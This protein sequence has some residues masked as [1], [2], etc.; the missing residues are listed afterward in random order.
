MADKPLT[1]IG[2]RPTDAMYADGLEIDCQC[3]RCGSSMFS[4]PCYECDDGFVEE[5]FGDDVVPEIGLRPCEYCGGVGHFW[6]CGSSYDWCT[7]NPMPGR[8]HV[9]RGVIEWFTIKRKDGA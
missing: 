4:E 8:E 7:A 5:D 1:H 2:P 6:Q 9:K 3:A